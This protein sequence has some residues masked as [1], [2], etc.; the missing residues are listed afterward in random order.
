MPETSNPVTRDRSGPPVDPD[1][2]PRDV[3]SP[4]RALRRLVVERGDVLLAIAAG[5]AVGSLARWAVGQA[6]PHHTGELAVATVV[7]N[8]T[9]AFALGV[10]MVF[11]LEVWPPTRLVRPFLG[12]GVLGGFTT[13]STYALDT[14]DLLRLGHPGTAATY[15]FGTLL[16]G[17]LASWGA[18]AGALGVVEWRHDR[19]LSRGQPASEEGP[20]P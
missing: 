17:L 16:A 6:L 3:P 8:V 18:M 11:V 7:V 13:F 19:R 2:T 20:Q 14:T 5:G 12:V 1:V 4:P 15:L 10:L 9:G